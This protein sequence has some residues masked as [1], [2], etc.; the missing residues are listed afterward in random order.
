MRR[1]LVLI[2][3]LSIALAS[4]AQISDEARR[5]YDEAEQD[6]RIGRIEQAK[7]KLDTHIGDFKGNYR[8]NA[9]RLLALCSLGL[10]QK[11]NALNYTQQLLDNNPYYSTSTSDPQRFTDMVEQIKAGRGYTITTAS[12][13][14]EKLEESPV[15]ITLI[16]EDMIESSGARNLK[17]VLIAFVPGM[18]NIDSNDDINISMRGVFSLGQ[19]KMLFMLNGHRLNSYSTNTAAPDF[20]ISLEKVKQIEVLRGPASSLYGGV[21]LSA[22]V[23]IITK[24]GRDIDG[25]KFTVGAGNYGQYKANLLF[26]KRYFDVDIVA[27]GNITHADGQKFFVPRSETGLM[28]SEG[29][30]TVGGLGNKPNYDLGIS[31]AWNG[32]R[33]L[34]NSRYSQITSP[35][36]ASYTFSPYSRKKYTTFSGVEPSY[37]TTSH[38]V[39]LSYSKQLGKLYLGG[40]LY[41]DMMNMVH[42]QAICDSVIPKISMILGTPAE[43]DA[44]FAAPG[45]YRYHDGQEHVYGAQAK[46]DYEYIDDG[47]HSG[48]LS[49]G[50]QF[51]RF[52]LDDSRYVIGANF[53]T[54]LLEPTT[55]PEL[56]KGVETN[57]SGYLQLKHKWNRL[58][59]NAGTRF[60]SKKRYNDDVINQF[61]PR[62]ALIYTHDWFTARASYAHSFVD[63]PYFYRK[64]NLF[65]GQGTEDLDPET[66]DS[67][68]MSL[69]SNRLLKGLILEVNGFYN[70]AN[71]LIYPNGV[72]H[73][74]A[75]E[76][77]NIG[78]EL[79]AMYHKNQVNA[80]LTAC[81]QHTIKAE[82]F[83]RELNALYNIPTFT[84]N[85][86]WSWRP[87]KNLNLHTH[88]N[89]IGSQTSYMM[90]IV[91][92]GTLK[93]IEVDPHVVVDLG[94]D[95]T[96]GRFAFKAN[97]HNLLNQN[98]SQGGMNTGLIRQQG[99][100]FMGEVSVKL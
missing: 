19:E 3:F 62:M 23:N 16:T 100:W 38:H 12:S 21:A 85:S 28:L 70:N 75:G 95:Y 10:D 78:A 29:D 44:V 13:K 18:T 24:E 71:N 8:T 57:M 27:W 72:M 68:Q 86:V 82:F 59:F 40:N 87:V 39:N 26:G 47:T 4:S 43:Y 91:K 79:S 32:F 30:I 74:N 11:D 22:V 83:G 41:I 50:A 77:K 55:V 92:G 9:Y 2:S 48:V 5:I 6:Y 36:T 69:S 45:F 84:A 90:E 96:L 94:A 80:S 58:I 73:A 7:Q 61:S 98:Y 37:T 25:A 64:S 52:E 31:F 20:S 51:Y 15:P 89:F 66:M 14:A 99:L 49:F 65:L 63:A 56:A 54:N 33:F 17:E 53:N 60:D 1:L 76:G 67:W 34:Y 81:Y 88:I 35:Y 46:G 93:E 97:V 42:Y